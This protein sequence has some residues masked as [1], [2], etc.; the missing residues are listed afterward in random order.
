[1][2]FLLIGLAL[3]LLTVVLVGGLV[4]WLYA[5]EQLDRRMNRVVADPSAPV[6]SA[7]DRAFHQSLFVADLHADTL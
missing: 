3:L 6:P 5:A 4:V 7:A 2:R 1:M